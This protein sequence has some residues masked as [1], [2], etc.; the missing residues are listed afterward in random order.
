LKGRIA[1]GRIPRRHNEHQNAA[2]EILVKSGGLELD[3]SRTPFI[4]VINFLNR[5]T[6]H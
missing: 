5:P 2:A 1:D 6:I 4:E 3:P